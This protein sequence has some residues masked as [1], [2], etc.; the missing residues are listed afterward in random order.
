VEPRLQALYL[1]ITEARTLWEK[2][3]TVY[4]SKL[5]FNVFEIRQELVGIR[6]EDCYDVDTYASQID[7]KVKDYNFCT[8]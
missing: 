7:Q 2:L 8:E 5:K 6:L 4:K 1:E 3:A